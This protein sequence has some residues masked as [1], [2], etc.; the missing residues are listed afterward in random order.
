MSIDFNPNV[1]II[2]IIFG[3]SGWDT[4]LKCN[5]AAG[6]RF[7]QLSKQRILIIDFEAHY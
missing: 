3:E 4:C 6:T 2:V 5:A 7:G 1:N